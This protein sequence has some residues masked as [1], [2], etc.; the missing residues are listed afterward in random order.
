MNKQPVAPIE[1][2]AITNFVFVM[3]IAL[4]TLAMNQGCVREKAIQVDPQA[5]D[6]NHAE[7][8]LI[9][10]LIDSEDLI[11]DLT[12]RLSRLAD[13]YEQRSQN[14]QLPLS[15]DLLTC[16]NVTGLASVSSEQVFHQDSSHA[17]FIEVGHWPIAETVVEQPRSVASCDGVGRSMGDDE[18]WCCVG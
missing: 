17:D 16:L 18:V 13:W 7:V 2:D 8:A 9:S 12:P 6:T 10:D 1:H 14:P 5:K 4:I 3:A 15:P 11:L